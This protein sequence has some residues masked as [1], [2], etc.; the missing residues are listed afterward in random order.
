MKTFYL[1]YVPTSSIYYAL[2]SADQEHRREALHAGV[3]RQIKAT[4]LFELRDRLPRRLNVL[5]GVQVLEACVTSEDVS[6]SL[7][8]T[9]AVPSRVYAQRVKEGVYLFRFPAGEKI[10]RGIRK[11]F[12]KQVHTE[13]PNGLIKAVH[14]IVEDT[15]HV[16][17]KGGSVGNN[18]EPELPELAVFDL[19]VEG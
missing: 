7:R 9:T 8:V 6:F 17:I 18:A 11:A 5:A 13:T 15:P 16:H 2:R 14:E 3:P 10:P 19:F 12:A 1:T 4:N